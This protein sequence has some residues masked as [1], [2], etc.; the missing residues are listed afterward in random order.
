[1]ESDSEN[2]KNTLSLSN[3][4]RTRTHKKRKTQREMEENIVK[5]RFKRVCVFCGSRTG[6]RTCYSDA[7]LEL[8]QELVP[9]SCLEINIII[10]ISIMFLDFQLLY[11]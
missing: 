9:F 6:K 11:L 5:S 8:G 3:Q 4:R 1:M 10:I 7:A 2:L